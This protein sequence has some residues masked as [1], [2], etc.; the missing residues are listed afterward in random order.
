MEQPPTPPGK[1]SRRGDVIR[2]SPSPCTWSNYT[3]PH[4]ETIGHRAS[5]AAVVRSYWPA[6]RP[7]HGATTPTRMEQPPTPPGK[8]SHVYL[9]RNCAQKQ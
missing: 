2:A 7:S 6:L 5:I 9:H 3:D 1:H 8:H 4:G